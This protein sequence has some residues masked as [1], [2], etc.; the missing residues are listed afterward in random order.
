MK[1]E[2]NGKIVEIEGYYDVNTWYSFAE[3]TK[4]EVV[5][6]RINY[7]DEVNVGYRDKNF[8]GKIPKLLLVS[9]NIQIV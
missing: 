1:R 4:T 9:F 8:S 5:T 7:T 2:K 6:E 3:N